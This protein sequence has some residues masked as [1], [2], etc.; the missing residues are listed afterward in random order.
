M[1]QTYTGENENENEKG[2]ELAIAGGSC[3]G[4]K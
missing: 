1:E 3:P 2:G 4:G